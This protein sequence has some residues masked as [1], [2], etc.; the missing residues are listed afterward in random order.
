MLAPMRAL[1]ARQPPHSAHPWRSRAPSL[2][3]VTH[4][5][6]SNFLCF[7]IACNTFARRADVCRRVAISYWLQFPIGLARP[8]LPGGVPSASVVQGNCDAL[9]TMEQATLGQGTSMARPWR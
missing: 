1:P 7:G 8:R 5:G 3:A 9:D 6:P 4:I 2:A